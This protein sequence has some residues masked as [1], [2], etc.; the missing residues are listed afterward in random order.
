MDDDLDTLYN[1]WQQ[2][3]TPDNLNRVVEKLAPVTRY[4]QR[5]YGVSDNP[6][7][8][9]QSRLFT[10]QA[11]KTYDPTAGTRLTTWAASHLRQLS[12]E[13]R[14]H[15]STVQVPERAQLEMWQVRRSEN[16]FMDKY[17]REPDA[18]E[19][20]D[21]ARMSV[22]KIASL[23]KM[24][25]PQVSQTA[26]Q[27]VQQ[28]QETPYSDEAVGYIHNDSDHLDRRILELKMGYGGNEI[29]QPIEIAKTLKLT[30]SQLS[31][32][33]AKLALRVKDAMDL[34]ETV[35]S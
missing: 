9:Q 29:K 7:L 32:R 3:P 13:K 35:N 8:R 25:R 21:H 6:L 34:L 24:F 14:K 15:M 1:G 12:R 2:D 26:M 17:G 31:R 5:A 19:L 18:V 10:A 23:R 11:V 20:A 27:G 4:A 28:L 30:P 22:P 16:D 33:S